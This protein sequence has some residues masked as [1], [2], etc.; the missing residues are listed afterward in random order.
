VKAFPRFVV[1]TGYCSWSIYTGILRGVFQVLFTHTSTNKKIECLLSLG[2]K[3][4]DGDNRICHH[5]ILNVGFMED[6]T[7]EQLNRIQKRITE[8]YERK[9]SLTQINPDYALKNCSRPLF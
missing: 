5:T 9:Q 1:Y 6:I 8:R 4:C 7:A 2:R 3:L